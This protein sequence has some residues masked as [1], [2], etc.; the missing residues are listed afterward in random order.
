MTKG[1]FWITVETCPTGGALARTV[2]LVWDPRAGDL[3]HYLEEIEKFGYRLGPSRKEGK[4]R[5]RGL[6]MRMAVS[7]AMAMNVMM[8]SLSYYFGL[9]DIDGEVVA[10]LACEDEPSDVVFAGGRAFVTSATR[11]RALSRISWVRSSSSTRRPARAS[12]WATPASA[13][14]KRPGP[15]ASPSGR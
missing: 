14:R 3:K 12:T 5:S 8:F 1:L 15:W 9:T 10:T 4:P 13:W 11:S 2:D 6:L 7:I